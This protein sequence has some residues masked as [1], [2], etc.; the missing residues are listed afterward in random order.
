MA[1]SFEKSIVKAVQESI[2]KKLSSDSLFEINYQDRVKIGSDKIREV[3]SS[4]DWNKIMGIVREKIELHIADKI[5]NNL[6]TELGTDIKQ[7]MCNTE[8]REDIRATLREKIR[9]SV[10]NVSE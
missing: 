3:Y 4:V 1:E 2:I 9:N 7:I 6:A 10:N 5:I 8:L